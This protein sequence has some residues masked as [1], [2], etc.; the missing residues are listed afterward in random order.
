M[1]LFIFA[2]AAG[3]ALLLGGQTLLSLGLHPAHL[4]SFPVL[5]QG[6]LGLVLGSAL[7]VSGLLGL[8]EGYEKTAERLRPLLG[9]RQA[10]G[11]AELAI[12]T[13]AE[14]EDHNRS[15]WKSYRKSALGLTLFLAGLLGLS[16][17]LARADFLFYLI[18]VVLGIV[19]LGLAALVLV[20]Q[21][22][23]SLRHT[24]RAVE[25]TAVSLETQPPPPLPD[26]PVKPAR[27][28]TAYTGAERLR[29]L[30][31][32]SGLPEVH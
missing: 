28:W 2:F 3:S 18:A 27:K 8:A 26:P 1:K 17:A 6:V 20:L 5:G 23:R 31:R 12:K 25:Q 14:L 13:P 15:F 16:A 29:H 21:G 19:L 7:V 32:A 9:P 30:R 24:H 4:A 22:M 10:A 11:D